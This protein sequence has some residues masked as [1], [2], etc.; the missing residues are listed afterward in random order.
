[1]IKTFHPLSGRKI[2]DVVYKLWQILPL[3]IKS[4]AFV[5]AIHPKY[6]ILLIFQKLNLVVFK[7]L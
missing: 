2:V 4:Y 7:L 1:M 5:L 3:I 6:W